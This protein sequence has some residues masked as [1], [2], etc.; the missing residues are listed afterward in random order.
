MKIDSDVIDG[1]FTDVIDRHLSEAGV[2]PI[3]D[4]ETLSDT[5][6]EHGSWWFRVW[7]VDDVGNPFEATYS[8]VETSTGLGLELLE[9]TDA[10]W[11]PSILP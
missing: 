7:G 3:G 1:T 8:V 11:L 2:D 10:P 5:F 4:G 6:Y 9:S